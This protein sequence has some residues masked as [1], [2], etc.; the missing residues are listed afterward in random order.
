MASI[1]LPAAAVGKEDV[2]RH[3]RVE[4]HECDFNLASISD[5]LYIWVRG[6]YDKDRGYNSLIRK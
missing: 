6:A 5:K 4:R 2:A 3:L 1:S